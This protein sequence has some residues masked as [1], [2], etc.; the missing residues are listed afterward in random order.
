MNDADMLAFA[1]QAFV[2]QNAP[3]ELLEMA[4][5]NCWTVVGSNDEDGAACAILGMLEKAQL[6]SSPVFVPGD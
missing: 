1:G 4:G 2:M 5:A 3:P 6:T